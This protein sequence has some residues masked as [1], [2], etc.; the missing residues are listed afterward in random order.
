[1]Q[2]NLS[3]TFDLVE[4]HKGQIIQSFFPTLFLIEPEFL[5]CSVPSPERIPDCSE[6][7]TLLLE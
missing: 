3:A 5:P 6:G 7:Q 1:M 2:G 4:L